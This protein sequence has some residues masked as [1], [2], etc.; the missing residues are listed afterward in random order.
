VITLSGVA[1][2]EAS[3]GTHPGV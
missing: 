3:G 2:G 1:W